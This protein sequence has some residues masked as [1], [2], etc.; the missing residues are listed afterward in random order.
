MDQATREHLHQATKPLINAVDWPAIERLWEPYVNSGDL[1]APGDIAVIYFQNGFDEGTEKDRQMHDLL[2]RAAANDHADATYCIAARLPQG[3][4]H[5]QLL[6]KAGQLGNRDAQRNLGAYYATGDWTGPKDPAQAV[7][8]YARAAE[9]GHPDAQYNLGF[10]YILGEGTAPDVEKGLGWL[11][12]A[13][14]QGD[15]FAM[16]LLADLYRN[17]YYNVPLSVE[18][19]ERWERL[20]AEADREWAL[21]HPLALDDPAPNSLA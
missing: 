4:E 13:A 17:G 11:R 7:Q 8:W 6:L 18:E 1:D 14:G 12:Q 3:E 9:Q 16:R 2:Q 10:M 21:K 5:D 20:Y 19:A 15:I